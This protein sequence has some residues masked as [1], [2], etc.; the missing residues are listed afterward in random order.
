MNLDSYSLFFQNKD[1]LKEISADTSDPEATT[2]MTESDRMAIAF[3]EVKREYLRALN[4]SDNLLESLDALLQH[5]GGIAFIEFKN[6]ASKTEIK[7]S[8]SGKVP[9]S[10][11]IFCD[12]VSESI[13]F[14][15]QNVDLIVVYNKEKISRSSREKIRKYVTDKSHNPLK[16]FG[17]AKYIGVYFRDAATYSM[18]EFD[19]FFGQRMDDGKDGPCSH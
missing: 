14:T 7:Q 4:Q 18:E 6:G 12:V 3:D 9:D 13:S 16:R 11:L 8:V 17:I 5:D 2:Y 19:R 1:T 15:R 10:L